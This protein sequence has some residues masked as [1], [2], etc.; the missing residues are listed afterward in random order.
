MSRY[1]A[2]VPNRPW[3]KRFADDDAEKAYAAARD[4]EFAAQAAALWSNLPAKSW[5]VLEAVSEATGRRIDPNVVRATQGKAAFIT[6]G[7]CGGAVTMRAFRAT[8]DAKLTALGFKKLSISA[9]ED[10]YGRDQ[11]AYVVQMKVR[12]TGKRQ[13][14]LVDAIVPH[15]T[16]VTR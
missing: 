3:P 7:P 10:L 14:V 2:L 8:L 12:G 11:S 6:V 4:A 9:R 13:D 15:D 1:D 16:A 5:A